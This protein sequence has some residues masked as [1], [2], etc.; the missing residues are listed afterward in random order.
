MPPA[1]ERGARRALVPS[2]LVLIAAVVVS[3][4]LHLNA[5]VGLGALGALLGGRTSSRPMEV[6]IDVVELGEPSTPSDAMESASSLERPPEPGVALPP[7]PDEPPAP[8]ARREDPSPTPARTEAPRPRPAPASPPP[9][10]PAPTPPPPATPPPPDDRRSIVQR[11][12]DPDVENPDARFL[13]DQARVVEEES[14]ANLRSTLRDDADPQAASAQA[15]D[16]STL[17]GND[18]ERESAD[19]REVEGDDRRRVTEREATRRPPHERAASVSESP[20]DQGS[21]TSSRGESPSP[22]GTPSRGEA[23]GRLA[24]GGGAPAG[25]DV[26]VTDRLGSYV[27]RVPPDTTG[28]GVG[29]GGGARVE[30]T[31]RDASG[32]GRLAGRSGERGGGRE[33]AS[34]GGHGGPQLG[35]SYADFEAVYGEEELRREREARL[36]ERRSRSPG[37]RRAAEWSAFRAAIENYVP[38]VRPGNQTALNAAAS[39]FATF[40]SDMHRRI[41]REFADRYIASLGPDAPEGLNDPSLRTTLEIAVNEDGSLYRVGIVGT[42]GNT[43]YDFGAFSSVWRAQPF[44]RPPG[45]IL[46]GDGHAWLHW[47]FDRG[48][49]HCGTWNAEPYLLANGSGPVDRGEPDDD[50]SLPPASAPTGPGLPASREG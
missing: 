46:S 42:S 38:E 22:E 20:S 26:L 39:P 40:L 28:V 21:A 44:P 30:G 41:H 14:V 37:A 3:L 45:I 4:G 34:G 15:D 27:V 19:L 48:P 16:S 9:V 43:L 6:S 13:A 18:S 29:E 50:P 36:E 32:L 10:A 5:Y 17:E 7:P 31:G 23:G 12:E 49:R 24:R 33:R 1:S 47:H 8:R 11:S 2:A 35:L 25:H